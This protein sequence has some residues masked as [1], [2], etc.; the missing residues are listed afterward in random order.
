MNVNNELISKAEVFKVP[1]KEDANNKSMTS[2]QDDTALTAESSA[3]NNSFSQREKGN[4]GMDSP[5]N[6]FKTDDE[7]I[8]MSPLVKMGSIPEMQEELETHHPDEKVYTRSQS[9]SSQSVHSNEFLHQGSFGSDSYGP[10]FNMKQPPSQQS[11]IPSFS[12][13]GS[14]QNLFADGGW[15]S[16]LLLMTQN[17]SPER[18][19]SPVTVKTSS[20]S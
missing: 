2:D 10:T 13:S 16:C 12:L 1:P 15:N 7:M 14:N 20:H 18:S 3:V 4:G 9:G 17:D 19:L 6:S 8:M 11:N 5:S